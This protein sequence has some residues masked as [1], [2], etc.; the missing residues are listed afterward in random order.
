[1]PLRVPHAAAI[2]SKLGLRWLALTQHSLTLSLPLC[3]LPHTK[4]QIG[5]MMGGAMPAGA[6]AAVGGGMG[7]GGAGGPMRG[8]GAGAGYGSGG[9]GGN[10]GGGQYGTGRGGGGGGGRG[11]RGGGSGGGGSRY[12]PY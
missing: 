8:G 3:C 9:R 7:E 2:D 4:V 6:L 12:Q 11:G 5:Y 10:G 1:M